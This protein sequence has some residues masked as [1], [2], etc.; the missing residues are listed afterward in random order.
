MRTQS[1]LINLPGGGI[2]TGESPY[3]AFIREIKE[4]LP[5]FIPVGVPV[6]PVD[7]VVGGISRGRLARLSQLDLQE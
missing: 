6:D 5:D 7:V 1:D 4:E 3:E 2:D